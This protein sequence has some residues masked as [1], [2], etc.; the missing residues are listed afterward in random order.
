MSP[1]TSHAISVVVP[2]W[3]EERRIGSTLGRLLVDATELGI[4]E[5]IVV[6]DGSTDRTADIVRSHR[7]ALNGTLVL[8]LIE[9]PR[10]RGKGAALRSGLK[11]ASCPLVGY[12]D[13]D[14]S[15]GPAPFAEAR[16]I[17]ESG[18]DVVV[19]YRIP[20]N[21][22]TERSGQPPLR[23]MLSILFKRVQR[24]I[25]GLPIGDTQCP[26]KLFRREEMMRIVPACRSDGW[27]FDVEV[28]L[29]ACRAG[30]R[31]AELPVQWKFVGGSTVRTDPRTVWRTMRELITIRIMHGKA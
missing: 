11:V 19:G 3:N 16:R 17:I 24:A 9:H 28:L 23:H 29:L 18:A 6:N 5:V 25:V 13:A 15:I 1:S 14:L 22:M 10:N 2:A 12:V 27:G 21:G 31:I 30:F 4:A 7:A 20:S 8:T 26:F